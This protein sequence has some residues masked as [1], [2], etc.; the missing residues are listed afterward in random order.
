MFPILEIIFF[1]DSL[2]KDLTSTQQYPKSI[3]DDRFVII[4]NLSFN[5][6]IAYL[7]FLNKIRSIFLKLLSII[8]DYFFIIS[9]YFFKI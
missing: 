7:I 1:T 5:I 2:L 6:L 3:E 9:R 4:F 8:M